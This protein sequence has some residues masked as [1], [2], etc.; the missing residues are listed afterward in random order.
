[1]SHMSRSPG[2]HAQEEEVERRKGKQEEEEGRKG[3]K[4]KVSGGEKNLV[5][6][7]KQ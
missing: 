2:F 1:M 7:P 6:C 4:K 3:K 5:H